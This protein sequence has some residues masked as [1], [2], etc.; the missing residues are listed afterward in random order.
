MVHTSTIVP[1]ASLSHSHA[2]RNRSIDH[3]GVLTRPIRYSW[4]LRLRSFEPAK[5][6]NRFWSVRYARLNA[7]SG[8]FSP[9]PAPSRS[10]SI[11]SGIFMRMFPR[12]S[13]PKCTMLRRWGV[14]ARAR[15][16]GEWAI[17]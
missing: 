5:N 12:N 7:V 14:V 8:T 17:S 6:S 13:V 11:F 9:T 2:A 16:A 3:S 4:Y 1:P 15:D 10:I